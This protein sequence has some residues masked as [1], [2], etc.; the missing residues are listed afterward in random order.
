MV[1]RKSFLIRIDE[2]LFQDIESWAQQEMRSVNGQIEYLLRQACARYKGRDG[3][4]SGVLKVD[5][6]HEAELLD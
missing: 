2:K 3:G 6:V 1:A 4:Q 5:A